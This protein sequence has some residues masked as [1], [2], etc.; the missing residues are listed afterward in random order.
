MEGFLREGGKE[1]GFWEGRLVLARFKVPKI[2][3]VY[4]YSVKYIFCM[5]RV[6]FILAKTSFLLWFM[7]IFKIIILVKGRRQSENNNIK[8]GNR[9]QHRWVVYSA[10]RVC[11][12]LFRKIRP[13]F[14]SHQRQFHY[15]HC[16]FPFSYNTI[17]LVIVELTAFY[18]RCD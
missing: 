4:S 6:M 12:C 8:D 2:K 1:G 10:C 3:S 14:S 15:L 9:D 17:Y 13:S 5:I 18:K 11:N 7:N 16:H